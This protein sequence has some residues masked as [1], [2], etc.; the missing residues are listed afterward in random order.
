MDDIQEFLN[1][2]S[3][4][5]KDIS[6]TQFAPPGKWAE[7]LVKE[8]HKDIKTT[9][10]RKVFTTIKSL[11][12]KVK[13]NKP[14]DNFDEPELFMLVPHL[15]YAKGRKFIPGRFYD[16]MKAIIGD[17]E[18]GKIK[19]AGDF[20]RFVD[21]MTAIIAYHKEFSAEKGGASHD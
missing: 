7:R 6:I 13:G 18:N 16:I 1:D 3:K 2:K 8:L 19:T 17:G 21:F 4:T 20:R 15:A 10:L 9:Q 14:E 12:V 11:E 5:F